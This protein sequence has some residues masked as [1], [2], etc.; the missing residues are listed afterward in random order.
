MYRCT[1][2][3]R[4]VPVRFGTKTR[5]VY[6]TVPPSLEGVQRYARCAKFQYDKKLDIYYRRCNILFIEVAVTERQQI[7]RYKMNLKFKIENAAKINALLDSVNGRASDHTYSK[8]SDVEVEAK[9]YISKIET[10]LGGKK[11][12]RGVKFFIQSGGEVSGG[13][14]YA[15]VGTQVSLECRASGWFITNIQRADIWARGGRSK[16]EFTQSHH[17]QAVSVL[18]S[19]YFLA[20]V[21]AEES[22]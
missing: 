7:W 13:Y 6:R 1:V 2:P 5:I 11:H 14:K 9:Y 3:Y 4:S 21:T 20:A 17:D 15:R 16:I 19:T 12:C 10:I 22:K 8:F 18:S